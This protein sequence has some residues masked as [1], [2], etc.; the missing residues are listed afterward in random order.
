[1][2]N[3]TLLNASHTAI[4]SQPPE[5][6]TPGPTGNPPPPPS[7]N[8]V[9]SLDQFAIIPRFKEKCTLPAVEGQGER[10]M[11]INALGYAGSLACES[12][13][14]KERVKRFGVAKLLQQG[15]YERYDEKGHAIDAEPVPMDALA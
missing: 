3:L 6:R 15:G 14:E 10:E 7:Y 11:S 8:V 9:L 5:S 1:M 4:W 12:E 2:A 13:G